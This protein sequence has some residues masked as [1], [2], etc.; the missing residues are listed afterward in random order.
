MGMEPKM[1]SPTITFPPRGKQGFMKDPSLSL[2]CLHFLFARISVITSTWTSGWSREDLEN[3]IQN[4]L[5]FSYFPTNWHSTWKWMVG[6]LVSFWDG[7]SSGA[8]LILRGVLIQTHRPTKINILS[9]E[10]TYTL[11]EVYFKMIFLFLLVGYVSSLEGIDSSHRPT[12]SNI[13]PKPGFVFKHHFS[14]ANGK[15]NLPG[16]RPSTTKRETQL[17]CDFLNADLSHWRIKTWYFEAYVWGWTALTSS[18]YLFFFNHFKFLWIPLWTNSVIDPGCFWRIDRW[19][20][21]FLIFTSVSPIWGKQFSAMLEI[22]GVVREI[23]GVV[24][25]TS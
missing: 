8:M 20:F 21:H 17:T 14:G 9:W 19:C 24:T 2:P 3:W 12:K 18:I 4:V 16:S 23:K 5:S 1:L 15:L 7:R 6:I 25:C 11:P 13:F 10:L 22:N